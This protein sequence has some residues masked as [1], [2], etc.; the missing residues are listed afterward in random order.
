[1]IREMR[2]KDLDA[3]KTIA[4]GWFKDV[5]RQ[6]I[7]ERL[8]DEYFKKRAIALVAE[9]EAAIV[10]QIFAFES[11]NPWKT[12]TAS[13]W[14]LGV[15]K[16]QRRKGIGTKLLEECLSR[17]KALGYTDV[18]MVVDDGNTGA[19]KLYAKLGFKTDYKMLKK[20]L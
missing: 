9:T 5:R 12:R 20:K 14:F 17:L 11:E 3:V 15:A 1:M 16:E 13:I 7:S 8:V 2:E 18:E 4:Q 19:E 6:A 10:G